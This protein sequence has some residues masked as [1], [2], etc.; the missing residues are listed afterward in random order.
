MGALAGACLPQFRA[1]VGPSLSAPAT[2]QLCQPL[3][4]RQ[5]CDR[6]AYW[7][8]AL[9]LGKGPALRGLPS[10]AWH[11]LLGASMSPPGDVTTWAKKGD[12]QVPTAGLTS[13]RGAR[14]RRGQGW[15]PCGSPRAHSL[16][17]C[18]AGGSALLEA[19][20]SP[21]TVFS[22]SASPRHPRSALWMVAPCAATQHVQGTSDRGD[23]SA[24]SGG[25]GG[26]RAFL[27]PPPYSHAP[28]PAPAPS[29]FLEEPP[30]VLS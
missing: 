8:C 10:S 13:S 25:G 15:G 6:V 9:G 28:G 16:R 2:H 29:R 14:W 3:P 21:A 11:L 4:G 7:E 19:D 27:A 1:H 24:A 22:Q 26:G 23:H 20:R 30:P 5:R 17:Q 18:L 12:R